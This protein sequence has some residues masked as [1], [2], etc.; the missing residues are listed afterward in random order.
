MRL[1]LLVE[2]VF[3]VGL[4]VGTWFGF[5]VQ[6]FVVG[7]EVLHLRCCRWASWFVGLGVKVGLFGLCWR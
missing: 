7:V 6:W 1:E 5:D 3:G 4:G 2:L